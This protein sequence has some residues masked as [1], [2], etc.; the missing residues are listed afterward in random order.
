MLREEEKETK[1]NKKNPQHPTISG[2]CFSVL[3][4]TFPTASCQ[5]LTFTSAYFPLLNHIII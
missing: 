1:P 5:A 4:P 2:I 3:L